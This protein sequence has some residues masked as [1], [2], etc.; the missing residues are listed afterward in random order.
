[1]VITVEGYNGSSNKAP[2]VAASLS[3][4]ISM[5]AGHKT[6]AVNLID[7]S[8]DNIERIV[9]GYGKN[10]GLAVNEISFADEGIDQLLREADTRKLMKNHFDTYAT[11]VLRMENRFDIATITKNNLFTVSLDEKKDALEQIIKN[12]LE[13]YE[14]IV[15]LLPPTNEGVAEW[16]KDFT[17][18]QVDVESEKKT[19][20]AL[21]DTSIVCITQGSEKTYSAKGNNVIYLI[22]E[23]EGESI[24]T[25]QNMSRRYLS[26]GLSLSSKDKCMKL[27]HNVKA[28]DYAIKGNLREFIKEN[29]VLNKENANYQWTYDMH[30]LMEKTLEE[31]IDEISYDWQIAEFIEM[32]KQE[33]DNPEEIDFVD[34]STEPK[35]SSDV[36]K[37][38][39][40][41]RPEKKLSRKEIRA[42]EKAAR[43]E[44]KAA[45][46]KAK[47]EELARIAEEKRRAEEIAR[48]E[49]EEQERKAREEAERQRKIAEAEEANRIAE[50]KR[51]QLEAL[52][53]EVQAAEN[54][55]KEKTAE[56]SAIPTPAITTVELYESNSD[57]AVGE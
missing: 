48:I 28:N 56:V 3:S 47:E 30:S 10:T 52:M 4:M 23:F 17:I 39:P 50:E 35:N 32:P 29:R 36:K 54:T 19:K 31:K 41:E 24:Y 53:A 45:E 22:T 21:V 7:S 11:P 38:A 25:V 33:F 18:E 13:V 57:V 49:R 15:L 20:K 5:A 8:D 9:M 40:I 14:D 2:F 1:M 51:K 43:E 37:A 16:I 46:R 12:A 55:A 34:Y 6:L 27:S 42:M 44:K 26:Q